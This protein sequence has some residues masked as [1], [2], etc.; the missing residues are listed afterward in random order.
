MRC[1]HCDHPLP[2]GKYKCINP[3]CRMWSVTSTKNID[4]STV[5]LSDA[6]LGVV[7]RV[8]T[9]MV[10]HCF[11]PPDSPGIVTTSVALLAGDPGAGKTTLCLQLSDFFAG[12]CQRETL[13]IANE[14]EDVELKETARRLNLKHGNKIRI[15]KAMGGVSHDIGAIILRFMPCFIVLD[16]V[17]KWSGEDMREAVVICQRLKDY[18]V[19][20]K[21]PTLV[22]N[23]VTK[24]GEHAGL[25]KMQHAVDTT[26][27]FEVWGER[28][29]DPRRLHTRKNR[30]GPAPV[31]QFFKMTG[32]GLF[33]MTEEEA[34]ECL[35]EEGQSR[36]KERKYDDDD[37]PDEDEEE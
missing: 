21:A 33:G 12:H 3:R 28:P 37:V 20:L 32:T 25:N 17:T 6:K 15:V 22:I 14:Q 1:I 29:D 23:Q 10:D 19:K 5:L 13:Y 4:D 34:L 30:N 7:E 24:G 16:S 11:G 35:K 36:P 27:M 31:S 2:E 26:A 18:S 9:N 8:I